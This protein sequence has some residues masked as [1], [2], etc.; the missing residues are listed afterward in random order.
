MQTF[1]KLIL[2]LLQY[3]FFMNYL[4]TSYMLHKQPAATILSEASRQRDSQPPDSP[5]NTPAICL[6]GS[7]MFNKLSFCFVYT[8]FTL[9]FGKIVLEKES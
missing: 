8:L 3:A 6:T 7:F 1:V 4:E 2:L 9:T 5:H